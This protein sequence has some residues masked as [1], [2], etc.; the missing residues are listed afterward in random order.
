MKS[1]LVAAGL[2]ASALAFPHINS[3]EAMRRAL[4]LYQDGHFKRALMSR[5]DALGISKAE[6]NCGTRTCPTFDAED[7]LV[8]VYGEHI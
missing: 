8:D 5:Q 1:S 2:V 4:E 6:T 3:P 7:Q